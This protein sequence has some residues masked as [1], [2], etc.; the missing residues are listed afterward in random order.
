M[1]NIWCV[2][3]GAEQLLQLC[4]LLLLLLKLVLELVIGEDLVTVR[5]PGVQDG[6]RQVAG[7]QRHLGRA[8]LLLRGGVQCHRQSRQCSPRN[9]PP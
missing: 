2:P 4:L 3:V 7:V 8:L 6:V 1:K 9:P 5:V